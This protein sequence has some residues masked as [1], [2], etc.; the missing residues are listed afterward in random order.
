MMNNDG[1]NNNNGNTNYVNVED[2]DESYK[3]AAMAVAGSEEDGNHPASPAVIDAN[4]YNIMHHNGINNNNI[5]HNNN[6][7][8]IGGG[9]R[10]LHRDYLKDLEDDIVMALPWPTPD[11]K[12]QIS[13]LLRRR[14]KSK[15]FAN[16]I[17]IVVVC[18]LL[19]SIGT[20]LLYSAIST[21]TTGAGG[22]T[23]TMIQDNNKLILLSLAGLS[24][25]IS[26]T[27]LLYAH[28][29]YYCY[30]AQIQLLVR[31][32]MDVHGLGQ[33]QQQH[34]RP[35]MLRTDTIQCAQFRLPEFIDV[36]LRSVAEDSI[37]FS[38]VTFRDSLLART[39]G[40]LTNSNNNNNNNNS[41]NNKS[42]NTFSLS[43]VWG[44]D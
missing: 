40:A 24:F 43:R 14:T 8:S 12:S 37:D 22:E 38:T 13:D 3:A 10:R 9:I 5:N 26:V 36:M 15:T 20:W 18:Y 17:T 7:N 19:L 34:Q 33:P 1:Y 25:V 11:D 32:I 30:D 42:S 16:R 35:M 27:I 39:S 23:T 29:Q 31:T 6:S 28:F 21:L 2:D 44:Y 41:N 4:N